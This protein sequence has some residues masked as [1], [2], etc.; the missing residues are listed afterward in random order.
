ME[1]DLCL[2]YLG[3]LHK[4]TVLEAYNKFWNKPT[5]GPCYPP[6]IGSTI[7]RRYRNLRIL[8][9]AMGL[10]HS[11]ALTYLEAAPAFLEGHS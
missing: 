6:G 11:A 4:L 8:K 9:S 1:I 5:G 2:A 10:R 7:P 3:R